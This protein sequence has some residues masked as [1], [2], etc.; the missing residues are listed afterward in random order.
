VVASTGSAGT[1]IYSEIGATP[2]MATS[3]NKTVRDVATAL[4]SFAAPGGLPITPCMQ[5]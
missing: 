3:S 1:S 5:I 2:V 4:L